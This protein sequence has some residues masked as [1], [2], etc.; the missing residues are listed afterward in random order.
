MQRLWSLLTVTMLSAPLIAADSDYRNPSASEAD[1]FRHEW[2][3]ANWDDGGDLSHYVFLN[4]AEFWPHSI[5]DRAGPVRQLA[6]AA[7]NDVASFITTTSAGQ[8]Q[9]QAYMDEPTVDGMI[10]LHQ[11]RVVFEAY[12]RMNAYDKHLYMSVS[13]PFVS[14]LVGVLADRE[15]LDVNAPIDAYLP[16]VKGSG[17]EGVSVVDILDMASGIDCRQTLAGVYDDPELC[18]YQFEAALGWLSP[19][20]YCLNVVFRFVHTWA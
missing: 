16:E 11:G 14:M 13:K 9:L 6:Q 10:V 1:R 3:I 4:M 2:T 20:I 15:A 7:R 17:W 5:I 8:I 18:Y 12:P 19:R